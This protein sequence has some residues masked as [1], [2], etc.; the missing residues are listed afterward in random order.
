MKRTWIA[1]SV[2]LLASAAHADDPR[3]QAT[4]DFNEGMDL[5]AAGKKDLA[6]AKLQRANAE[7]PTAI[8][9]LELGRTLMLLGRLRDARD[10][11]ATVSRIGPRANES[12][13][14]N[15]AR[16]EAAALAVEIA[17]R[18]PKIRFK[19][20]DLPHVSVDGAVVAD[21]D[22]PIELDPGPHDVDI[23]RS[24]WSGRTHVVLE[25]GK[26]EVV[27]L[28]GPVIATIAPHDEARVHATT[29]S[30]A[31]FWIGVTLTGAAV[32]LGSISGGVALANANTASPACVDDHCASSV[33]SNVDA[34][35]TWST[36]STISFVAAG[37]FA[38]A[39]IVLYFV[40]SGSKRA[41]TARARPFEIV[42]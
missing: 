15:N 41:S 40:T 12:A 37:A 24:G 26:S 10:A 2:V 20:G 28:G 39:S 22:T 27:D 38:V 17:S 30:R 42:F 6:L 14:A 5:R 21:L 3:A 1:M 16:A 11:L 8:T 13:R 4:A 18:I 23:S 33:A 32:A 35:K 7:Y 9:G 31:P 29:P 36:V 34:A 19:H 25:E